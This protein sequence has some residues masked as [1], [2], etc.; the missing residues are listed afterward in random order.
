MFPTSSSAYSTSKVTSGYFTDN[1]LIIGSGVLHAVPKKII[2]PLFEAL[3]AFHFAHQVGKP[4]RIVLVK[5]FAPNK[6]RLSFSSCVRLSQVLQ[7]SSLDS[8]LDKPIIYSSPWCPREPLSTFK[9]A[10]IGIILLKSI[11]LREIASVFSFSAIADNICSIWS[12]V[13][14][15]DNLFVTQFGIK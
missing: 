9:S 4:Y 6:R 7:T 11:G 8:D 1:A 3:Q 5:Y 10:G 12:S 15:M 14:R 13:P 2:L